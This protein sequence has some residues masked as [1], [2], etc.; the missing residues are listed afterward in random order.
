MI[1]L[2]PRSTHTDTLFPDTSL[3]RSEISTGLDQEDPIHY[4]T[5][6]SERWRSARTWPPVEETE[7]LYFGR[8]LQLKSTREANGADVHEVDFSRGTGRH[9]R[10]ER[11]AGLGHR[12]CYDDWGEKQDSLLI[13]SKN[14]CDIQSL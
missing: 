9:T 14:M 5:M 12:T 10:N 6:H 13:S 4:F 1:R 11:G 7:T 8:G 3:F 2:P